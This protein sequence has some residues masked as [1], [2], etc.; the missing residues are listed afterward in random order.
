MILNGVSI[1]DDLARECFR[2]EG[3]LNGPFADKVVAAL[4]LGDG[5]KVAILAKQLPNIVAERQEN[6][7]DYTKAPDPTTAAI[8]ADNV[9]AA[10]TT[11]TSISAI[12][13]KV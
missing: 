1:A 11:L 10:Q 6:L 9:A 13:P 3:L 4:Q 8:L 12:V 7:A 2:R 5:D